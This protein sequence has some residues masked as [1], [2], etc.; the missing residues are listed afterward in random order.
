MN[1]R[2]LV[3]KAPDADFLRE[4]IGRGRP[5]IDQFNDG[6]HQA[7]RSGLWREE[8]RAS[9]QRWSPVFRA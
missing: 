4:M 3:E 5:I 6:E 1:L 9:G 2:A 7:D 8:I